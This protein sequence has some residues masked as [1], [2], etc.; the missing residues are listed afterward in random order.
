[1]Q[2]CVSAND[3]SSATQGNKFVEPVY[4]NWLTFLERSQA[5][6]L[7]TKDLVCWLADLDSSE[8]Q[9]QLTTPLDLSILQKQESQWSA[10]SSGLGSKR[11]RCFA[12]ITDAEDEEEESHIDEV[13]GS[14][15]SLIEE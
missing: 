4:L 1:M 2:I 14:D 6:I 7:K 13:H 5:E 11:L 10:S 8:T 9:L 3:N 12:D 15:Q